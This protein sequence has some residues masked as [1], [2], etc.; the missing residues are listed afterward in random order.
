ME[1]FFNR[2]IMSLLRL[3]IESVVAQFL[4][5]YIFSVELTLL[6]SAA[7]IL[8]V[9]IASGSFIK[10]EINGTKQNNEGEQE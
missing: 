1:Q 2:V 7:L 5:S 6:K 4:M 8:L 9:R 10:F 3:V